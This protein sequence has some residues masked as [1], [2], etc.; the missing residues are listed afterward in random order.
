MSFTH[1]LDSPNYVRF[2]GS[3]MI[4]EHVWAATLRFHAT[5]TSAGT[6]LDTV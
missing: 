3:D 6:G 1:M 4:N 2:M 5:H